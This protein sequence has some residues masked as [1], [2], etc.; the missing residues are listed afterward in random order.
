VLEIAGVRRWAEAD[1]EAR[2]DVRRALE[3]FRVAA[4]SGAGAAELTAA[5]L[6]IHRSLVALTG[7]SRLTAQADALT[8]EVRLGLA[9]VDRIRRNSSQ[10]V[11]A[12]HALV[13]LLERG[14]VERAA[15][16]LEEHLAN[17]EVSMLQALSL[18]PDA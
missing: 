12:H 6:A 10:Q 13:D 8:A 3:D 2:D 5:H 4:D 15:H 14:D 7:S 16:D 18:E 17:A 1:E 11:D 9:K